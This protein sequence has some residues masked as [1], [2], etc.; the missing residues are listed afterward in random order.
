VL[1]G[2]I[3]IACMSAV[4]SGSRLERSPALVRRGGE[5]REYKRLEPVVRDEPQCELAEPDRPVAIRR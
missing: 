1:E 4:P 2:C 5:R 3:R